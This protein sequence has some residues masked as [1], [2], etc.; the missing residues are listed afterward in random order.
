MCRGQKKCTELEEEI[1]LWDKYTPLRPP[2]WFVNE[3]DKFT[4]VVEAVSNGEKSKGIKKLTNIKSNEL[5]EWYCEHGQQS[6]LF[7]NNKLK[8]ETKKDKNIKLDSRRSPSKYEKE[9]FQ[10]DS[11]TCQYCGIK[12]IPRDVFDIFSR[13]VGR[14]NF[15]PTGTNGER[16]GIVLAF[17]ACA[18]HV[19]PWTYGGKTE[20][21]NLV[22]SCWACNFGKS[23]YT[24]E[25]I[26]IIDPRKNHLS[27]KD[28]QGLT[29]YSSVLKKQIIK[30]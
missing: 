22:T 1:S 30:K 21:E 15:C 11:Y 14:S 6:G 12:V 24:L 27:N 20:P 10:R 19:V 16:H 29:E 23:G 17:R 9:V 3:V 2:G 7:R 5:R 18:D 4:D 25:E 8:I 13:I 26:A 28:W